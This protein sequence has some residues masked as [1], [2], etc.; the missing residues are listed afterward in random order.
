MKPRKS[1]EVT[2]APLGWFSPQFYPI[3]YYFAVRNSFD[4]FRIYPQFS[5]SNHMKLQ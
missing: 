1:F 5:T 3:I 4:P 2:K